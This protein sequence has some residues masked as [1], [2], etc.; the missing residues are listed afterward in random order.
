MFDVIYVGVYVCM[1]VGN[2]CYV[3]CLFLLLQKEG[4]SCCW[5]RVCCLP[6]G[7]LV[8]LLKYL[9]L[10]FIYTVHLR[11]LK[12]C[13]YQMNKVFIY[14]SNSFFTISLRFVGLTVNEIVVYRNNLFKTLY[15]AQGCGQ[16]TFKTLTYLSRNRVHHSSY[17][18]IECAPNHTLLLSFQNV[19]IRVMLVVKMILYQISL[20]CCSILSNNLWKLSWALYTIFFGLVLISLTKNVNLRQSF[21]VLLYTSLVIGM[22]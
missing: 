9:S 18:Y 5:D 7:Y 3:K 1:Y 11:T 13:M 4:G 2:L 20:A 21:C 14:V 16:Y 6:R 19:F 8:S 17:I 12:Y 15:N 10:V 22:F